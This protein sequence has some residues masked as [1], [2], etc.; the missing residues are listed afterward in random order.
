MFSSYRLR[1][2][3]MLVNIAAVRLP[4]FTVGLLQIGGQQR[5]I[6]QRGLQET[7]P[8]LHSQFFQ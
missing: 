4:H 2:G 5:A 6:A 8:Q 1:H 7:L 3:I